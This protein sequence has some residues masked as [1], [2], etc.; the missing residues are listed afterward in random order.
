[1]NYSDG[2]FSDKWYAGGMMNGYAV[3][4]EEKL[5]D[6]ARTNIVVIRGD[7]GSGRTALLSYAYLRQKQE[8]KKVILLLNNGI[9]NPSLKE[10]LSNLIYRLRETLGKKHGELSCHIK[11]LKESVAELIREGSK[12]H[13]LD[14]YIDDIDLLH[15]VV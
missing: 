9:T 11:D 15:P 5:I 7:S 14:I 6:E 2:A 13:G 1:M 10:I 8:R 4:G 3:R 12:K